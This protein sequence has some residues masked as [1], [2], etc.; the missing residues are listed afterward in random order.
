MTDVKRRNGKISGKMGN[1]GQKHKVT[2]FHLHLTLHP[3]NRRFLKKK[4]H[5]TIIVEYSHLSFNLQSK[6][7]IQKVTSSRPETVVQKR[8]PRDPK[9]IKW[10]LPIGTPGRLPRDPKAIKWSISVGTQRPSFAFINMVPF[11]S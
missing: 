10:S 8:L 4:P 6:L 1:P 11:T 3:K 7:R 9:A 5:K 2:F